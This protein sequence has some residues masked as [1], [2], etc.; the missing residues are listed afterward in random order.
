MIKI[1]ITIAWH[2]QIFISHQL[3]GNQCLL[4]V[5]IINTKLHTLIHVIDS[6]Q[7]MDSYPQNNS[8]LNQHTNLSL[9]N[10]TCKEDFIEINNTCLPRCDKFELTTHSGALL[11][12][13]SELIASC[14]GVLICILIVILS[15]K[16]YK[17]M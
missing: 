17:T 13:Y 15:I 16:N 8:S 6:S 9:I 4:F 11:L 3:H 5:H 10:I 14:L 7:F 2:T 1:V 12:I